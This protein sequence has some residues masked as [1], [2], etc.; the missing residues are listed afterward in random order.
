MKRRNVLIAAG[1]IVGG[2][3]AAT[4]YTTGSVTRSAS[5]NVVSDDVGLIALADGTSGGLITHDNGQLTIDLT[6]GGANG[7]NVNASYEFGDAADAANAYAFTIANYDTE[8][9]DITVDFTLTNSDPDT[10]VDNLKFAL[11]GSDGT[12]LE[13]DT[14][15]NNIAIATEASA[16]TAAGVTSNG[17]QVLHVVLEVDTSGLTDTADLSGDL[18]I[19]A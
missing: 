3:V 16:Y 9:R 6:K 12:A 4:A 10:N 15:G 13:T 17:G 1:S 14:N 8:A 7:A 18:V 5:I 2:S 11:F 19:S